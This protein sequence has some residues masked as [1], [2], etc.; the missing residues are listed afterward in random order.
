[1]ALQK[2][3]REFQQNLI[4]ELKALFPG[5]IVLKNDPNYIQGIPD[6]TVLYRGHWAMLECK[7]Y[8]DAS[9]QANQKYYIDKASEMSFGSFIFPENKQEVLY[10]LQQAF[11]DRRPTRFPRSK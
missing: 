3:E 10:D 11:R 4:K 1:M 7:Q 8:E 9:K 6:L 5:C 2:A